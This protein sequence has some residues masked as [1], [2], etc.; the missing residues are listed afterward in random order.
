MADAAEVIDNPSRHRFE[1]TVDGHLAELVYR[2]DGDRMV[3]VHTGVPEALSGRGVGGQLVTAAVAAARERG[4]TVD[5]QCPFARGWLAKH[6]EVLD[7]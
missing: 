4:L 5:A 3:L 7:S 1:V 2:I 6:P